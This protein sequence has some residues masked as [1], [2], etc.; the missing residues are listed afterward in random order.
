MPLALQASADA[1]LGGAGF[2]QEP[3]FVVDAATG[4]VLSANA[5][6]WIVWGVEG[7]PEVPLWIDRAMP[8][9]D[10]LRA[11]AA[12]GER[13]GELELILTF[14]T[15]RGIVQPRCLVSGP[16]SPQGAR[17]LVRLTAPT[18]AAASDTGVS[19]AVE[20]AKLAHEIRTPLSAVIS[21]AEVLKDEHF[22]PLGNACYRTY[23]SNIFES[24]RHVL[25]LVDGM[26][27]SF[28]D[29]SGASA[30]HV[31]Q[32]GGRRRNRKLPGPGPAG[33][34]KGRGSTSSRRCRPIHRTSLPMNS[35]SSRSC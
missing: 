17:F 14:W 13:A 5:A 31:H 8:A 1:Q 20:Q 7:G 23:A 11:L 34:R 6:G 3:T 35:A 32:C 30:P 33:G 18:S 4:A 26:L 19:E 16:Q 22:G 29:R 15:V 28:V 24:A 10:R 21:Y 12:A 27:Q 9:L 25:R 2:A